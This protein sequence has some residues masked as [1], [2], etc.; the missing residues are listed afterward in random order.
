MKRTIR[1]SKA[2]K[3]TKKTKATAEYIE[4]AQNHNMRR[5]CT[6]RT[7]HSQYYSSSEGKKSTNLDK[8]VISIISI[9]E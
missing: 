8:Q 9:Q 5:N 6:I 7:S 2:H 1:L 3:L 4:F